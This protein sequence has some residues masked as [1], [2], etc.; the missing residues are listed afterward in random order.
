MK[1]KITTTFFIIF[2]LIA[3]CAVQIHKDSIDKISYSERNLEQ[4]HIINDLDELILTLQQLETC[5][6]GYLLTNDSIFI[7]PKKDQL[8]KINLQLIQLKKHSLNNLHQT[9]KIEKLDQYTQDKIACVLQS[10]KNAKA[11][12]SLI[13][14][15]KI[16][17][18][19]GRMLMDSVF[20][21]SNEIRATS[22]SKVSDLY[23]ANETSAFEFKFYFF[24]LFMI[25]SLS[26]FFSHLIIIADINKNI[27]IEKEITTANN[28]ISTGCNAFI[29]APSLI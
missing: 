17:L 9:E 1:V 14:E 8:S 25:I 21:Y 2:L 22:I 6:R 19:K 29:A 15:N 28:K 3:Y 20:Y 26:L 10:I 7:L 11:I 23:Q 16:S 13:T 18:S 4:L 24:I 5:T 12:H 27:K